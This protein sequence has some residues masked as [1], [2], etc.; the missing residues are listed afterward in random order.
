MTI[1]MFARLLPKRREDT[2]IYRRPYV[3]VLNC[4]CRA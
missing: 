3:E 1:G 4:P 2:L